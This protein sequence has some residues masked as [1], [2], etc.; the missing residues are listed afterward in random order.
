MIITIDKIGKYR[1]L[2]AISFK[3]KSKKG[4][5]VKADRHAYYYVA[6]SMF[7][8]LV[9]KIHNHIYFVIGPYSYWGHHTSSLINYSIELYAV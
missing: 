1:Y 6:S 3:H 5:I 2:L 4:K 8:Y 7:S 9:S